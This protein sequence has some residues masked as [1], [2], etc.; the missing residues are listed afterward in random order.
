[1]TER[2]A[3]V[4][5]P[6][7]GGAADPARLRRVDA[8]RNLE[9]ILEAARRLLPEHPNS[10]MQDIATEAGVHRATVH[11]HF[12]SRD[13]LVGAVRVRAMES[14]IEECRKAAELPADR[15][16]D[17]LQRMTAAILASSDDF[18]LFRFTTWRD[19]RTVDRSAELLIMLVPVIASA[20]QEGDLRADIEPEQMMI[21][22]GG[23]LMNC[24]PAIADGVMT[25]DGAANFLLRVLAGRR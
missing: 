21:A 22:Y 8:R 10:S 24:E 19:E 12:A 11:R 4:V 20:Q 18:R 9:A 13:D 3:V 1:M 5:V 25:V 7:T 2:R 16:A 17:R 6:A 15:A 14:A 23:L